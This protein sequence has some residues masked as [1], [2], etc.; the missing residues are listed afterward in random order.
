MRFNGSTH[1]DSGKSESRGASK[2]LSSFGV[3]APEVNPTDGASEEDS[4][5]LL[6]L[7][8]ETFVAGIGA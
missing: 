1:C 2:M 8:Q 5:S 4:I 3:F 7:T 6:D